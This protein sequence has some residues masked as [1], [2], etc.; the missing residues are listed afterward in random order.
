M[1][2]LLSN[3]KSIFKIK[4]IFKRNSEK[5]VDFKK[6]QR[7][8]STHWLS[9][10]SP[11]SRWEFRKKSISKNTNESHRLVGCLVDCCLGHQQVAS[12]RWLSTRSPTS[13]WELRKKSISKNTNESHWL[14]GCL[15]W[16]SSRSPT[17][18]WDYIRPPTS[19]WDSLM[20][21]CSSQV[22][23][24]ESMRLVGCLCWL[25]TRSPTSRWL[26]TRSPTSRIDSLVVDSITNELMRLVDCLVDCRLSL[27]VIASP[28]R[29]TSLTMLKLSKVIS[30]SWLFSNVLT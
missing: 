24:N 2:P 29:S 15:R 17:S 28:L 16:L 22:T 8:A 26:W 30:L 10:R 11:T 21:E 14:V 9:T 4:N 18:R 7:V 20:V 6:H 23:T 3:I 27:L 5:K 19:R 25:S 13:R 12:T 1:R